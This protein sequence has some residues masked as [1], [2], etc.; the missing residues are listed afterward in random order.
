[1]VQSVGKIVLS[2]S[3]TFIVNLLWCLLCAVGSVQILRYGE[4]DKQLN[5]NQIIPPFGYSPEDRNT[6]IRPS[7]DR[8]TEALL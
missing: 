1:M 2:K 8:Q 4:S 5:L 3:Y 6:S 7:S